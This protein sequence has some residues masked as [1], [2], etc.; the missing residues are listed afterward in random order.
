MSNT[1]VQLAL[2]VTDLDEAVDFYRRMFGVEPNKVHEGYAN[3]AV[4][5]PPLKLVLIENRDASER[6]NHLGVEA[7]DA[8]D[9]SAALSRFRA[10]GLETSVAEKDLCCHASQDKVF[11]TAPD[12]PHGWWEYYSVIEDVA[13][14]PEGA[15]TS[16]C[17]AKCAT[18]DTPASTCCG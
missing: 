4:E 2:N 16:V 1:R 18:E 9:V 13:S 3:F 6:L 11:V 7:P 12:A 17:A 15:S 5:D 8:E 14:N 10:A